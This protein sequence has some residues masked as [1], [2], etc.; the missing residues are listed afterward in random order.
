MAVSI[1][2]EVLTRA[3]AA[4]SDY[5]IQLV[6]IAFAQYVE[7]LDMAAMATTVRNR[8]AAGATLWEATEQWATVRA[9]ACALLRRLQA[10]GIAE[11][12]GNITPV[13]FALGLAVVWLMVRK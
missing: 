3:R 4:D 1:P 12:T 10:E 6:L 13:L 11:S 8:L 5:K 2:S 7:D 9:D